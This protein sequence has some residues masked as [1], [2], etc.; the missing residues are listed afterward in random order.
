MIEWLLRNR[1]RGLRL[2]IAFALGLGSGYL[3]WGRS[4]ASNATNPVSPSSEKVALVNQINPPDGYTLPASFR[5]IG[6]RF[7][8]L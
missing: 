5:D 3:L 2:L 4:P 8:S 1:S 7:F 6:P